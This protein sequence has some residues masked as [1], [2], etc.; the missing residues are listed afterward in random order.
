VTL[1]RDRNW[2]TFA[3]FLDTLFHFLPNASGTP[4]MDAYPCIIKSKVSTAVTNDT[5]TTEENGE[6]T[7]APDPAA[8]A[9]AEAA[10][11]KLPLTVENTR[12]FLKGL[13]DGDE[14]AH[15]GRERSSHLGVL[16]LERRLRKYP[17]SRGGELFPLQMSGIWL[18]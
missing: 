10:P 15:P 1:C 17:N 9:E 3:V 2:K 6:K 14:V 18:S 12:V 11:E 13:A 4:D 5:A 8:E 7:Q 16:E